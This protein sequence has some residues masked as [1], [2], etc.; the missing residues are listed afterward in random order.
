[1]ML[2]R[3][4]KYIKSNPYVSVAVALIMLGVFIIITYLILLCKQYKIG[5]TG[6]DIAK[7]GAVGD[8]VGGFVGTIFS[9]AG[10]LFLYLTLK[11][12]RKTFVKERFESNFFELIKLHRDN[13]EDLK[14]KKRIFDEYEVFEGREV[15][16]V[17]FQEF[18]ECLQDVR[19]FSNSKKPDDYLKPTYKGKLEK[20]IKEINPRIDLIEYLTIDVAYFIFFNGLDEEGASILRTNFRK[21]YNDVYFHK[22][23]KYLQLKPKKENDVEYKLWI[24]LQDKTHKERI[25]ITD[26]LY[27]YRRHLKS[28]NFTDLA[29]SLI[30]NLTTTKYYSGHHFRLGHYFRHLFQSYKYLNL[31]V[32]L[33]H[34]ERYFYGKTLRAQLSTYEQALLFINSISNLGLKWEY[35]PELLINIE[36]LDLSEVPPSHMITYYNLIKNLPGNQLFG[37]KYKQYYPKVRYEL[38]EQ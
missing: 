8:F 12:Q 32:D 25:D 23:I 2:K 15:F 36:N 26:E 18:L 31:Q 17:L 10:F 34:E 1:M 28:D 37:I 20:L 22:L 14:Y 30:G 21:K 33:S 4:F 7:T 11:D 9:L 5:N 38:E 29:Q 6:I 16:K 3:I 35:R 24:S 13:V 27:L 19:R